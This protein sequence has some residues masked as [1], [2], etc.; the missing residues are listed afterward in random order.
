MENRIRPHD[1]PAPPTWSR[2]LINDADG[3]AAIEAAFV[4]PIVIAMLLGIATFGQWFMIAHTI[5]Q[6]AD[7]AARAAVAGLN[8]DDRRVMVNQSVTQSL[9]IASGVDARL[10]STAT[11]RSGDYYTVT[12]TYQTSQN[13][14][15]AIGI[16]PIPLA[17]I[18]RQSTVKL[19]Y[20]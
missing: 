3:A 14:A 8:D 6:A 1:L 13:R 4:L 10:V 5:Q 9:A 20:L 19:V 12:V 16:I 2:R 7:E 15:L 18:A 17:P 11:N